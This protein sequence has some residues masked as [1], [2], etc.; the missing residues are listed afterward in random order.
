MKQWLMTQKM[1]ALNTMYKNTSQK[2]TTYRSP[3]GVEKQLD[4][5]LVNRRYHNWS[6]DAEA[7]DIMVTTEV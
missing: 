5:I 3:T 1:V 4:H 6:R 7:N 2:Q